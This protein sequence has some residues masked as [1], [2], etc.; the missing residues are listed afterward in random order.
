MWVATQLWPLT[1]LQVACVF[2]LLSIP[3]SAQGVKISTANADNWKP[4][5]NE[6]VLVVFFYEKTKIRPGNPKNALHLT[7][8]ANGETS[9]ALPDPAPAHLSVELHLATKNW[10]C[11]CY[12]LTNTQEVLN[13]GLIRGVNSRAFPQVDL[14]PRPGTILFTARPPTFFEWL[15][16]PLMRE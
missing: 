1:L 12:V 13:K 5:S 2:F 11:A 10:R 15:L 8:D 14:E 4:L 7:T 16:G 6:A 9:F 3:A